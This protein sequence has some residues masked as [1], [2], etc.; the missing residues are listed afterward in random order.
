MVQATLFYY[1]PSFLFLY[2]SFFNFFVCGLSDHAQRFT[3]ASKEL[4]YQAI[5][6]FETPYSEV[7]EANPSGD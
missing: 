7:L 5:F 4:C 6:L 2:L 3:H 1:T